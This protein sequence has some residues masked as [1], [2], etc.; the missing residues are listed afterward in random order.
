MRCK[1][2]SKG[3][4]L[5]ELMVVMAIVAI[6]AGV[7]IPAYYNHILRVTQADAVND[8]LDVKSAEE[9]F[10]SQYNS[11]ADLTDGGTFTDLL[12]FTITD[13]TNYVFSVSTTDGGNGFIALATGQN[14]TKFENNVI[15]V[16]DSAD[17]EE[18]SEP[19]GFK[20][21]LLF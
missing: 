19:V 4:S 6:L 16:T 11:Y 9:M 3:F 5:I 21:S 18:L 7:A 17:P 1:F 14:N 20:L 10:Y 12:S 13:S 8:L 2:N 15:R